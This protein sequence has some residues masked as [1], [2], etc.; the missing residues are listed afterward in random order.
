MKNRALSY[1]FIL[2]FV[3]ACGSS[4][5]E[6]VDISA[7]DWCYT[8]DFVSEVYDVDLL[9]GVD[10]GQG[11]RSENGILSA[12]YIHNQ[13][14]EARYVSADIRIVTGDAVNLVSSFDVFGIE[15]SVQGQI[16]QGDYQTTISGI[17]RNAGLYSDTAT[18]TITHP[19][20]ATVYIEKLII[21][22]NGVNPFPRNGCGPTPT[23]PPTNTPFEL[24]TFT[25]T[26]TS[27]ATPT[28]TATSTTTPTNTA[29]FTPSATPNGNWCY[30]LLNGNSS[31]LSA[32][33]GFGTP[34]IISASQIEI[35]HPAEGY[36]YFIDFNV[37]LPSSSFIS[38]LSLSFNA[39]YANYTQSTASIDV[40]FHGTNSN[41]TRSG[42]FPRS[43]GST[44]IALAGINQSTMRLAGGFGGS[45]SSRSYDDFSNYMVITEIYITG[46]GNNPFPSNECEAPTPTSP[47]ATQ[48]GIPTNTGTPTATGTGGGGNNPDPEGSPETLT[49]S[50]TSTFATSTPIAT[51]TPIT[52]ITP[53]ATR[54]PGNAP[55]PIA[56]AT[57]DPNGDTNGF[58]ADGTCQNYT[59]SEAGAES[60]GNWF[61]W[62]F[63]GFDKLINCVVMPPINFMADMIS[64]SFALVGSI[65]DTL[66]SGIRSLW[67]IIN[68]LMQTL[69]SLITL[70][71]QR[72]WD[73]I[74]R[75]GLIIEAI[76]SVLGVT[77]E[78]FR[79]QFLAWLVGWIINFW[80]SSMW[81]LNSLTWGLLDIVLD[82]VFF[83]VRLI[84]Q[85]KTFVLNIVGFIY[86][87]F[88]TV[89][90]IL[91]LWNNSPAQKPPGLPDCINDPLNY[92]ICAVWYILDN[93]FFAG[94]GAF[95]I[96]AFIVGLFIII[97]FFF[98]E[99]VT[100]RMKK[101]WELLRA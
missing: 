27:T 14:V 81:Y 44:V 4:P 35:Q 64:Q 3:A 85:I 6:E 24:P 63:G 51:I 60:S 22:G 25:P 73:E 92:D 97:A 95:I 67:D 59:G 87:G 62:L 70:W 8:F 17:P 53:I 99:T 46:T 68:L 83:A 36:G 21:Y 74:R 28:N 52:S 69:W 38:S 33:N 48:T 84:A 1:I 15:E 9:Y 10:S 57:P 47:P 50:P 101:I 18:I 93:T 66:I 56:T 29:T 90:V 91:G 55:T 30:T 54:T 49:P 82:I 94:I 71:A 2:F 42:S 20:V 100:E 11:L 37:N 45:F 13:I 23:P 77:F 19:T 76:M 80:V 89:Q 5:P 79:L 65:L 78:W 16:P 7:F 75:I 88:L 12:L 41:F 34:N 61:E 40:T 72:I 86:A 98:L 39:R 32:N 96:P 58:S 43:G 31:L 26:F